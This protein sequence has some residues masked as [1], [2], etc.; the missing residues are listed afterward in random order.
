MGASDDQIDMK[1]TGDDLKLYDVKEG[2]G[3]LWMAHG[4][5][6]I[7]SRIDTPDVPT[8]RADGIAELGR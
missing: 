6:F 8:E 1:Q 7:A 3:F 5:V 4:E 2:I